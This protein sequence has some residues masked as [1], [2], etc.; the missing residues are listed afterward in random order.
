MISS[1]LLAAGES[2]RMGMPKQLMPFGDSTILEQTVDNLLSSRVDE[3]IVVLGCRAEDIEKR[4]AA[5]PVKIAMNPAYR[6]GMSTSIV[7]GLA[8][9]DDRAE[10]VMFVLADQPFIDGKIIN[11]LVDGFASNDRGIVFP[12]CRGSRG[13]PI[14]FSIKYRKELLELKGDIGGRQIIKE[15]PDDVL[16][17]PVDSEGVSVDIDTTDD[18]SQRLDTS[19]RNGMQRDGE[20]HA[21]RRDIDY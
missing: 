19:L 2:K 17:I 8:L 13:H 5:K 6:Q 9:V 12:S 4:I 1:I 14:I 3:I 11:Q 7:A 20:A 15:H 16:E 18:F 10:A 21:R